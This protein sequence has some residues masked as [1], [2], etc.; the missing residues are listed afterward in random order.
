MKKS[1]DT[2]DDNYSNGSEEFDL[3]RRIRVQL[4]LV[5]FVVLG[6]FLFSSEFMNAVFNN[7]LDRAGAGLVERLIFAFKPTVIAIYLLFSAILYA[8]I[9]KY[10]RPLFVYL[11]DGK[12]YDQARKAAINIPRLIILFQFIAWTVG[13]TLYYMLKGWEA[14]SGIPFS[15]GL[16]LKMAVGLPSGVYTSILFN[17][18]LIPAKEKLNIVAM[19]EGENDT[20]S[21]QRDYYVVCAIILFLIVNFSYINYYYSIAR[22]ETG[23]ANFY[24]PMLLTALF[25]G[26]VSFGLMYLSKKEYFIQIDSIKG[27]LGKMA[28]GSTRLDRRIHIINYNELGETAAYVNSILNNFYTLLKKISETSSLLSESSSTLAGT[29][30]ENAA[31]SNEQASSTAEIVSTMEGLDKL[32]K[33]IGEQAGKVEESA[34]RMKNSVTDGSRITQK[35]IEKM[36][37]VRESYQNTIEGMRNLGEHIGGIWEI[38]K[39]INGIAGQIKIIAFNAALEASSAGE[40]GKN[41]EIVASEI[42]RLADNTVN[43]TNEIKTKI[44]DI[45]H[46]SDQLISSSEEDTLKIHDAWEMSHRLEEVFTQILELSENSLAS[47]ASM[48]QSVSQ[49]INAFEEIL[50]TVKQ[51]SEGVHEFTESI[52]ETKRTAAT[53]EETVENLNAIVESSSENQLLR[54]N[55][56]EKNI[57]EKHPQ[58]AGQ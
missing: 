40:E 28:E 57:K 35:N 13:T 51:I 53:L 4:A 46:A 54:E 2:V 6:L 37:E 36:Q 24:L 3:V 31:H 45:Q 50:L 30:Q 20:F 12:E 43:S 39:I 1:K 47:A 9:I 42:R 7:S 17:L 22:F 25:Y 49:Q 27:V 55:R 44:G 10:L 14:E 16:P 33:N 19:R 26:L 29:S 32:S 23:F 41:F 21:R 52:E 38:V 11:T 8:I 56:A 48:N 34:G 58:H 15:F 5:V 18:I